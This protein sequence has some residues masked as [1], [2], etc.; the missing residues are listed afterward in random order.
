MAD[1]IH[2]YYKRCIYQIH[3]GIIRIRRPNITG[4]Q[5]NVFFVETRDEQFVV[6]FNVEDLVTK[7]LGA[8]Q[9]YARHDIPVPELHIGHVRG[10]WY[11]T[12]PCI[13]GTTLFEAIGHGMPASRIRR[14]YGRV[15]REFAK[16]DEISPRALARYRCKY[17]HQVTLYHVRNSNSATLATIADPIVR[18]LNMGHERNM[19]VYHLDIT[20]K[21]I[22]V[23]D[24]DNITFLDMDSVAICNRNFALGAVATKY[25]G[26]GLDVQ[27]LY[28]MCDKTLLTPINRGRISAMA[29]INN[30][31]KWLL[32][33]TAQMKKR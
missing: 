8:S 17:A 11:E 12:Y 28:D 9:L 26:L 25:Q 22:V 33:R 29:N 5:N 20:P 19:G 13:P 15:I 32:W 4:A 30:F 10:Q 21:N 24:F 23:D 3:S 31:G 7:N 1:N 16:M 2:D 18:G 14:I 27:E 6:K